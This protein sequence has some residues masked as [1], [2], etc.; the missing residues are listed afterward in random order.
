M[1]YAYSQKYDKTVYSK[2]VSDLNDV[3]LCLNP[4]CNAEYFLKGI[5]SEK[6]AHFCHNHCK[7]H[8][9]GCVY[10]TGLS[11]YIS[12]NNII[13]LP[14]YEIYT[15]TRPRR[16]K[17]AVTKDK[18]QSD[19]SNVNKKIYVKTTKDIFSYCI[20]NSLATRYIDELTVNDIIVDERNI[21]DKGNFEGF[22]GLK[23]LLG[24]TV[25]YCTQN[26]SI[27]I[28]TS[29]T[30]KNNKRVYLRADIYLME[31]QFYE[32]KKYIFDT[33]D[34][35]SGHAIAVL[36]EWEITEKYN[37]KCYVTEPTNVI[38]KFANEK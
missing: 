24:Y 30:T 3:F 7:P 13:K 37:I 26:K 38:Y 29:A 4:N 14:L 34:K 15:H 33:F 18:L 8:I 17:I 1:F 19:N 32:I 5:N 21:C 6:A 27:K 31:E 36:A 23:I 9:K 35:F 28:E 22:S 25:S 11:K 16:N 12:N 10:N 20:A 2:E